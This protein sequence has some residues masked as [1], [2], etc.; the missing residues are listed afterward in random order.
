[1]ETWDSGGREVADARTGCQL[2]FA[3]RGVGSPNL[4]C[5]VAFR[6]GRLPSSRWRPMHLVDSRL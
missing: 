1:M 3:P 6:P 2:R 5:Q 4:P